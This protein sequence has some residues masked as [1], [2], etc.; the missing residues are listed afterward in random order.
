[1]LIILICKFYAACYDAGVI[2]C[3]PNRENRIRQVENEVQ[4]WQRKTSL[5]GDRFWR[6]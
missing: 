5:T 1:M 4:A 6:L 3:D 2:R